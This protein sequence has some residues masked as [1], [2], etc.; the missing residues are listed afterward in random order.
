VGFHNYFW[1]TT[2]LCPIPIQ[3]ALPGS[4]GSCYQLF[5]KPTLEKFCISNIIYVKYLPLESGQILAPNLSEKK[6]LYCNPA[7]NVF[8]CVFVYRAVHVC[9]TVHA[10][11]TGARGAARAVQ[12]QDH[13]HHPA[14]LPVREDTP[15]RHQPRTGEH[16]RKKFIVWYNFGPY[17]YRFLYLIVIVTNNFGPYGILYWYWILI[18]KRL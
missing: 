8:A 5:F 9:D 2:S 14:L 6:S 18:L 12:T 3:G 10:G 7:W 4:T 11:R 15:L 1:Q 16:S 17:M 13:P